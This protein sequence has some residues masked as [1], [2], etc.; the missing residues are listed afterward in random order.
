LID[1]RAAAGNLVHARRKPPKEAGQTLGISPRTVDFQRANLLKKLGAR[2][3]VD[4]VHEVLGEYP[5]CRS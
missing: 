5:L 3:T 4:L 2:K 1:V